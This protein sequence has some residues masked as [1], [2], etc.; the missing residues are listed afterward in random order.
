MKTFNKRLRAILLL[1][2]ILVFTVPTFATTAD[3]GADKT[4]N[5]TLSKRAV[6]LKGSGTGE[7]PL[8]YK[9]YED[10]RFI[11]RGAGR[12][13]VITQSGEHNITLVVR[14]ANGSSATDTMVVTVNKATANAGEDQESNSTLVHLNG[15]GTGKA[16]LSYKWY[17]NAHFIAEGQSCD[18]NIP[19]N[20]QHEITL[21]VT[22]ANGAKATDKM[23]VTVKS[24]VDIPLT[25]NA[26]PDKTLNITPSN[27]AVYLKGSGTGKAPLSYKWYEGGKF[28]GPDASRWYILT[29]NGQHEITLTVTDANGN[30]ASDTMIVTVKNGTD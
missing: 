16:P 7:E 15:S 19:Q 28:I 1:I 24:G 21:V 29:Q 26:G 18:Y 2:G 14:D 25:A 22:D 27:R 10:G 13:Y 12:W 8:T 17:E 9:W 30:T 23:I 3:A 11:G 6:Y 5:I 4:L 20:G